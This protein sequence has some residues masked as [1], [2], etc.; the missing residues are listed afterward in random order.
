MATVS[1][2]EVRGADKELINQIA[3]MRKDLEEMLENL[4]SINVKR[5]NTNITSIKSQHGETVI[6]GPVLE[7]YDQQATPVLR[8]RQGYDELTG[9]FL[10]EMYNKAGVKTIG[11]DSNGDA[12][13]TGTITS[14]VIKTGPDGTDH[15]ELTGAGLR[16]LTSDGLLNGLVFNPPSNTDIA[17]IFLYHRGT[18]LVEFYDDI[19]GYV[20]RGA[21]GATFFGL[22]GNCPTHAYGDWYFSDASSVS[23]LITNTSGGGT[24]GPGG[25]DGHT[26]STPD[27]YHT[28]IKG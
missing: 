9:D 3:L 6:R 8:L 28:V 20:L 22:G 11:I 1:I 5:L 18:K 27:H 21:S 14:S 15:L 16:G 24:T 13:F 10:F 25:A 23:G 17:D 26:H 7:M 2:W 19:T 4:D 12:T